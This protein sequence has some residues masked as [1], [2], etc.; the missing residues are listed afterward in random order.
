MLPEAQR[1]LE[2]N[3]VEYTRRVYSKRLKHGKYQDFNFVVC[4]EC[5]TPSFQV[6]SECSDMSDEDKVTTDFIAFDLFSALSGDS[7]FCPECEIGILIPINEDSSSHFVC[8][9][10]DTEFT[11]DDSP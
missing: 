5:T 10:C 4:V 9:V 1:S 7:Q 3:S 8:D 11:A 2:A 6:K